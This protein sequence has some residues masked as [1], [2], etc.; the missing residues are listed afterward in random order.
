MV[1]FFG[2]FFLYPMGPDVWGCFFFFFA[3]SCSQS[4]RGASVV[5]FLF[6]RDSLFID[7]LFAF[8]VM[9]FRLAFCRA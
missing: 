3:R 9:L 4:C 7:I 2:D 1:F 5:G 6:R 8:L